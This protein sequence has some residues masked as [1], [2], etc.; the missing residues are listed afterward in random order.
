MPIHQLTGALARPDVDHLLR[1]RQS[2]GAYEAL[3]L[4]AGHHQGLRGPAPFRS[5]LIA[6]QAPH[7]FPLASDVP[8]LLDAVFSAVERLF[9][10][11]KD[12]DDDV[13]V[14]VFAAFGVTAVHPFD[15]G[16]G[17]SAFD[18]AQLLLMHRFNLRTPPWAFPVD[19][20]QR[21]GPLF[22]QF[23][24]PS[25]SWEPASLLAL[26]Q[27]LTTRFATTRLEELR[28]SPLERVVDAVAFLKV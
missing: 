28:A 22:M 8:A 10:V 12:A 25:T 15:N 16:N 14:A 7:V 18:F 3:P 2:H 11:A 5:E 19:G 23:D 1:L 20:H 26:A 24:E 17:R 6:T 4:I 21:L 13:R 9:G 27:T